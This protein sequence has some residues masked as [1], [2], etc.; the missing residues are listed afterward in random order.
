MKERDF[1]RDMHYCK[2]DILQVIS[3]DYEDEYIALMP[4]I[5]KLTRQIV[6]SYYN[7]NRYEVITDQKEINNLYKI[8]VFK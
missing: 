2:G 4:I 1:V 3:I 8:I 6:D 5:S 7:R